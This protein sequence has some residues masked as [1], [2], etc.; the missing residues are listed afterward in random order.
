MRKISGER[1]GKYYSKIGI[2]N[3]LYLHY[4]LLQNDII[5]YVARYFKGGR[6]LDL[7][8]GNQPYKNLF[9]NA[10]QYVSVDIDSSNKDLDVI[11]NNTMLPFCEK[12]FDFILCTQVLEHVY[13][14]QKLMSEV[15]RVMRDDAL[16]LITFPM[17]WE[18]HE[19]PYDYYRY[20]YFGIEHLAGVAGLEKIDYKEQ[21]GAFAV[22]GQSILNNKKLGFRRILNPLVNLLFG[23]LDKIYYDPDNTLNYIFIFKKAT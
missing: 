4:R 21:G 19:K 13:D 1:I 12:S 23:A 14:P 15:Y 20:T 16:F 18:L 5:D 9:N 17:S 22:A 2:T 6:V 10:Q 7:G 3:H 8:A 11:A